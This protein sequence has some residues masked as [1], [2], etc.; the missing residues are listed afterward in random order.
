MLCTTI[1]CKY[2]DLYR[3]LPYKMPSWTDS[4][5]QG[6]YLYNEYSLLPIYL[7]AC[8]RPFGNSW[9]LAQGQDPAQVGPRDAVVS[10][11]GQTH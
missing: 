1:L 3:T 4:T 10:A 9:L 11:A 2:N 7:V 6:E 8:A 5:F